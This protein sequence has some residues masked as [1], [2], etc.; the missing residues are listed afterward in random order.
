MSR[1]SAKKKFKNKRGRERKK[2]Y[3]KSAKKKFKNSEEEKNKASNFF[4][5]MRPL[6]LDTLQQ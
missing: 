6:L 1:K 3:Q 2:K 5:R 4:L